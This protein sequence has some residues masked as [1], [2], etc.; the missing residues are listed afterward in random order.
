MRTTLFCC[1][2]WFFLACLPVVP[3]AQEQRVL[4]VHSYHPSYSWTADVTEGARLVLENS[5]VRLRI[6]HMDTKRRTS[7]A[8]KHEAGRKAMAEVES[9]RPQVVIAAD[10]NAQEYFAKH[11]AGVDN[12]PAVV[13]AGLNGEPSQYGYPAPNVTGVIERAKIRQSI[14]LLQVL[15][16]RVRRVVFIADD[17]P[18]ARRI[19]EYASGLELPLERA[20]YFRAATFEEWRKRV[21]WAQ[22]RYDAL[23]LSVY[24]TVED[25]EQGRSMAPERVME[26][27]REHNALPMVGF[28]RWCVEDGALCGITESGRE[29]GREAARLALDI[30]AG[31]DPAELPVRT[32]REGMVM[33]NLEAARGLGLDVPYKYIK[34][35]QVL[36]GRQ[37]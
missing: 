16:P 37:Q 27:T 6:L 32:A 1:F 24:H 22:D 5:G 21:L 2:L 26:W 11:Y 20:D 19:F 36:L 33:L 25:A 15:R 35:A 29:Q 28:W 18:T 10:D 12:A 9:F 31:A 7:E 8:W 3:D 4:L 13:F 23:A 34:L 17:S 14:E 30:L